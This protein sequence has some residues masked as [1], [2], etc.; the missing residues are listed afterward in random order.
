MAVLVVN[1]GTRRTRGEVCGASTLR[2]GPQGSMVGLTSAVTQNWRFL[3]FETGERKPPMCL[4]NV[5]GIFPAH[6]WAA[7]LVVAGADLRH[8]GAALFT[9]A[10]NRIASWNLSPAYPS[11]TVC[12]SASAFTIKDSGVC[13]FRRPVT[14]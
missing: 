8:S 1:L 10:E 3:R 6:T 13:R 11:R 2:R 7:E 14:P 9:E 12:G 4:V 5:P